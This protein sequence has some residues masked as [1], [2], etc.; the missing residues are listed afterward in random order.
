MEIGASL[1]QLELFASDPAA[2]AAFYASTLRLTIGRE[3]LIAAGAG[4][5]LRSACWRFS[6]LADF[7]AQRLAVQARGVQTLEQ[8]AGRFTV[9]DPEGR[10]ISFV[11]P[12]DGAQWPAQE[13]PCARL[14]HFAVRTPVPETLSDFYV[15]QLGFVLSDQVLD[16]QGRLMAVFLRTD[17]EH[18]AMAIFRAPKPGFDHFSLETGSWTQLR[19]WADHI[20]SVGV[21]LVWGIGRHGPGNDTFLMVRDMDGNMGEISSDLEVCAPGRPVGIWPHRQETL[22]RWG[23]AIMRSESAS[24]APA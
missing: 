22:N 17:S 23:F 16:A 12:T 8:A 18:H 1:W 14:Q 4:G 21:A 13:A 24:R 15:D 9:R 11:A 20:A 10:L 2:L 19:D 7:Q 5:Q 3:L 6:R